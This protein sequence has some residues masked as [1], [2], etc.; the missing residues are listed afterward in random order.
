MMLQ[1]IPQNTLAR[2]TTLWA[3]PNKGNKG[4]VYC[5]RPKFGTN[6]DNARSNQAASSVAPT[7]PEYIP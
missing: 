1:N 6:C 3:I 7:L 2:V 4:P 5:L